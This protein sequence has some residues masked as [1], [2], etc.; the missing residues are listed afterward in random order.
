MGFRPWLPFGNDITQ[1]CVLLFLGLYLQGLPP[2][3]PDKKLSFLTSSLVTIRRLVPT[4]K[5]RK[6]RSSGTLGKIESQGPAERWDRKTKCPQKMPD[7]PIKHGNNQAFYNLSRK[8]ER[9]NTHS[10]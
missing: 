10:V 1:N 7:C 9:R 3:H 8:I 4:P 5:D 6:S 2:L